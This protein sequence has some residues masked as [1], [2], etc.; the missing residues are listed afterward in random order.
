VPDIPSVGKQVWEWFWELD[1]ARGHSGSGALPISFPD[2]RDWMELTGANPNPGQ[3][4]LIRKL[5]K[6]Y[7]GFNVSQQKKERGR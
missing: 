7:M 6:A 2:I 5:D 1:S 3:I 4:E